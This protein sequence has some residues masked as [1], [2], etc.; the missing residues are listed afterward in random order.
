M[1]GKTANHVAKLRRCQDDGLLL[2]L[3]HVGDA[4][5]LDRIA[6]FRGHVLPQG[7]EVE[8]SVHQAAQVSLGDRS[9][10]E[11]LEP[12]VDLRCSDF[13]YDAFAP[14]RTKMISDDRGVAASR[15]VAGGHLFC[16]VAV[17]QGI[18]SDI[19]RP[20]IFGFVIQLQDEAFKMLPE[21]L[22]GSV[23]SPVKG[24][25]FVDPLAVLDNVVAILP[26]ESLCPL[27]PPKRAS[28]IPLARPFHGCHLI[29]FQGQFTL[30]WVNKVEA[31]FGILHI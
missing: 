9:K 4:D 24:L 1:R 19:S 29:G 30:K 23:Q 20:S 16:D 21:S 31:A 2:P 13:G 28:L 14:L 27:H 18:E 5:D 26:R 22:F 10:F 12:S 7:G 8:K 3:G 25:R 6:V 15:G 11:R 17:E